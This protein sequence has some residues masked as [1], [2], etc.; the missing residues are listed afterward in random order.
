MPI[1]VRCA[2]RAG[3]IRRRRPQLFLRAGFEGSKKRLT[4]G[5]N[6]VLEIDACLSCPAEST[7]GRHSRRRLPE[8]QP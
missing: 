5:C 3:I 1:E 8:P 2:D 7:T 4:R 6:S